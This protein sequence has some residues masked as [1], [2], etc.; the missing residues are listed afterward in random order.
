M[1]H[2]RKNSDNSFQD[3]V[4]AH[5]ELVKAKFPKNDKIYSI[6]E[7]EAALEELKKDSKWIK[8]D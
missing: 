7:V 1:Y 2:S 8:E 4:D 5:I 6:A 3:A